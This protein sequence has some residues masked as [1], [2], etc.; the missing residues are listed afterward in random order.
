MEHAK[1][2][3]ESAMGLPRAVTV[4]LCACVCVCVR[5]RARTCRLV[6]PLDFKKTI[7]RPVAVHDVK[8]MATNRDF[9]YMRPACGNATSRKS[10]KSE[11][12]QAD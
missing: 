5:A 2:I 1:N 9:H 7:R 4:F 8:Q 11:L 12:A 3:V 6:S 10:D